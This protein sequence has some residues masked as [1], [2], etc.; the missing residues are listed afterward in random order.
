MKNNFNIFLIARKTKE[1]QDLHTLL[2][3]ELGHKIIY[4]RKIGE[5]NE[6]DKFGGIF[7]FDLDIVENRK[8][9]KGFSKNNKTLGISK[10][11]NHQSL[12]TEVFILPLRLIDI[13]NSIK[14][15][16]KHRASKENMI[17]ILNFSYNNQNSNLIDNEKKKII[18]LTEMENK[19]IYFLINSKKPVGKKEILKSVWGHQKDLETHTLESLIYRLRQKIE[20]D[21]KNPKI[22]ISTGKNYLIKI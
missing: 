2:I 6:N 19:F 20:K 4:Y 13:V 10:D 21:I 8:T 1:F 12:D 7:I 14:K 16:M 18:N 11:K 22:I 15:I 3:K 9:L 5:V 17:D